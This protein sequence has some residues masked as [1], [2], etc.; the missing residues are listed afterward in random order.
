MGDGMG[1]WKDGRLGGEG[2]AGEIEGP[3]MSC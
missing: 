1:A 2:D 3:E